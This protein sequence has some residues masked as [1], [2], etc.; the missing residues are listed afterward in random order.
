MDHSDVIIVGAGVSG[1]LAARDLLRKGKKVTVLE[2]RNRVG[3]RI[4]TVKTDTVVLEGG[5]DFIHGGLPLTL[6][7]LKEYHIPYVPVNWNMIRLEGGTRVSDDSS[8]LHW[9]ELLRAM[10]SVEHDLPLDAFLQQ[11][12]S[13]SQYKGLRKKAIHYAQGFDVADTSRIST[14]GLH[15]EW[16]KEDDHQY[17]IP[18]GYAQLTDALHAEVR[19]LGNSIFLNKTVRRI[20]WEPRAVRVTTENGHVYTANQV[21]VTIPLGVW[22]AESAT[23]NIQFFPTLPEKIPA[24]NAIGFGSATK[25]LL[26]WRTPFWE[27]L[28]GKAGFIFGETPMP[29][30]WTHYPE[31]DR[32]L[33]GW[34]GGPASTAAADLS[35]EE[36]EDRA[37]DSLSGLFA[38]QKSVLRS[39]LLKST[40]FE[41][42]NDPFARGSYSYPLPG[43]EAAREAFAR[44]VDD[45]LFFAGEACYAGPHFGTVEAAIT[46]VAPV[47][48]GIL[49]A[50]FLV[51]KSASH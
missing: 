43:Y 49:K 19:G 38:M 46:S 23:E 51:E 29:T 48:N 18:G 8:D 50:G 27:L 22:R 5:P 7:L 10:A 11:K 15:A 6:G 3:G 4:K 1:L 12:F 13:D 17:R 32:L 39:L 47:V 45:T 44:P 42:K 26:E 14:L 9:E 36:L 35:P 28:A 34:L 31:N 25:I 16:S 21:L 2:G 40:V 37:L 20:D 30:F 33:T 24:A 41:W